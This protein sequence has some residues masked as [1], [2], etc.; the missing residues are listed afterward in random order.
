MIIL[1]KRA[2]KER[3]RVDK[4]V[5]Q[6]T[7]IEEETTAITPEELREALDKVKN[8]DVP[9]SAEDREKYFMSQV[10]MGEEL[11]SQGRVPQ[12]LFL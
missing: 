11:S 8:E 1:T 10:A 12:T 4:N 6:T 3:K 2:G 9:K 5:A 7:K